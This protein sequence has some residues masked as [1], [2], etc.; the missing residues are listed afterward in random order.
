M[1]KKFDFRFVSLQPKGGVEEINKILNFFFNF[2]NAVTVGTDDHESYIKRPC[3]RLSKR[4]NTDRSKIRL[5]LVLEL[6]CICMVFGSTAKQAQNVFHYVA[7]VNDF[8]ACIRS[9]LCVFC[10]T[11]CRAINTI[12]IVLAV[13]HDD[14]DRGTVDREASGKCVKMYRRTIDVRRYDEIRFTVRF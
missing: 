7:F 14:P 9:T 3:F 8:N 2:L 4:R 6:E 11:C 12:I 13:L 5:E 10:V 1:D